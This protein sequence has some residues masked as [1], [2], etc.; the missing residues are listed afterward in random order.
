VELGAIDLGRCRLQLAWLDSTLA[1]GP[2]EVHGP[3]HHLRVPEIL[4]NPGATALDW[5]QGSADTTAAEAGRL[6]RLYNWYKAG[7]LFAEA[8][9]LFEE[10]ATSGARST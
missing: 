8:E 3:A 5:L 6:A 7:P 4:M 1:L 10:V 2:I 9:R